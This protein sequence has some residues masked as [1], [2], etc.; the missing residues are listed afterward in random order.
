MRG[1]GAEVFLDVL[2]VDHYGT[3]DC[4]G[5]GAPAFAA[6]IN[7]QRAFFDEFGRGIGGDQLGVFL[8]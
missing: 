8:Y 6:D 7:Q 4:A 5:A 3:G 1:F 2:A